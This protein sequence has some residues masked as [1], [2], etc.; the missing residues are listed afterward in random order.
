MYQQDGMSPCELKRTNRFRG[1][2]LRDNPKR[3][4]IPHKGRE[5]QGP[6]GHMHAGRQKNQRLLGQN[7]TY[8][9]LKILTL[10]SR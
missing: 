5:D 2:D 3:L 10:I 1:T 9:E 4:V 8:L 7:R 6:A